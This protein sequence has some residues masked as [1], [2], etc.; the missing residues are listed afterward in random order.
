M[1]KSLNRIINFPFR[2]C[3]SIAEEMIVIIEILLV[4]YW[5][6]V[7]AEIVCKMFVS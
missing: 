1:K 4:E 2:K 7:L 3:S 5:L 6:A